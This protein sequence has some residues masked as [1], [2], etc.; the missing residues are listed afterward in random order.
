MKTTEKKMNLKKM[1]AI[2]LAMEIASRTKDQ[3]NL[4]MEGEVLQMTK[5]LAKR[6]GLTP[7]QA[8]LFSVFVDQFTDSR[9]NYRD[10]ANH[11][12]VRPLQVLSVREEID[13]L[14]QRGAIM[15]RRDR[16]GDVTFRVPNKVLDCLKKD[17]LPEPEP[18][19]GLTAQE[20][21]N[22][23]FSYLEMRDKEEIEDD[24]LYARLHTLIESN[25]QL[26]LCQRLQ[27]LH[28]DDTD[29]VL[30][31]AMCMIYMN[32]HDEY[33]DRGDLDDYFSRSNFRRHMNELEQGSHVLMSKKLVEYSNNDGQ[34]E[35]DHWRITNYS[36]EEILAE[37]HLAVK[38]ES[39]ANVTRHE[40]ISPKTLYYNTRVSKQ[41]GEL[42]DLLSEDRMQRVMQR[43]KD[44]GMRRGFTCLFYGGPGTGKTET[45]QQ[46][47]RL[48]GRDIMLV[49]VPSIRS[50]WVGETEQNIKAVFERYGK[51][52]RN[53]AKAPILLFNEADAL[54]NKRAEGATRS[55][56]KM[57]N[58]M[59][60]IILQEMEQLEGIMIATTNLTGSLDAAFERRFLYKIEFEKP[61]PAERRH[62]WQSMLPDL[63]EEDALSLA[64]RFDFSGGQIENIARKRIVSDILADR[65]SIDFD[66]ILDSCKC[67]SL[68]K[69]SARNKIGFGLGD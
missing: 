17:T 65:D 8:M 69:G 59:Q 62:I 49:D 3:E 67:E 29:L 54:L 18:I 35:T 58:A 22:L 43:L 48:T 45:A 38:N 13:A 4:T 41:V 24:D 20:V 10:I 1:S 39:R 52:A 68:C 50:K 44:R 63:T 42:Q 21:M 60:N 66:A 33:I 9:I 34:V 61:S 11:F 25:M 51:L 6:L 23:V 2:A 32:D 27:G 36:K 31:L 64:Q 14:V 26:L 56:D 37:L 47:A 7:M 57:E 15:R 19:D 40:D 28:L 55:V 5:E 30:Y 46:L 53:N 16:D 12:D